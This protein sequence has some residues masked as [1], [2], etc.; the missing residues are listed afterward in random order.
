M[1]ECMNPCMNVWTHV[2]RHEPMYE[3]MNPCM[4]VWTHVWMYE[5]MYECMNPCM[6]NHLWKVNGAIVQAA[7]RASE[8]HTLSLWWIIG[9]G[10]KCCPL[11]SIAYFCE[12]NHEGVT[13]VVSWSI[14]DVH[15]LIAADGWR[16]NRYGNSLRSI[17]GSRGCVR[18]QVSWQERKH[19][20]QCT[21]QDLLFS[22]PFTESLSVA[23]YLGAVLNMYE[24]NNWRVTYK[25]RSF[26]MKTKA[27][28]TVRLEFVPY[29]WKV[30]TP[31]DPLVRGQDRWGGSFRRWREG[32]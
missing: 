19:W 18:V 17:T 24:Q 6:S 11:I 23:T 30:L 3:C 32:A 16:P 28:P 22:H 5:P 26:V 29:T 31:W 2:W 15:I 8:T 21:H 14:N 10:H 20:E 27:E 1:Y 4:N 13:A 12:I 25:T 7:R 9:A